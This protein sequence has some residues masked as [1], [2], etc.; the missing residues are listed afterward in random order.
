M[1]D[2]PIEKHVWYSDSYSLPE[3]QVCLNRAPSPDA[4]FFCRRAKGHRGKCDFEYGS[5]R[6]DYSWKDPRPT[7]GDQ[8]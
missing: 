7:T 8:S 4:D 5:G 3:S 2:K 1:N 6:R